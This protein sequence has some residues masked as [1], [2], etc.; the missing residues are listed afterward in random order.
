M[1]TLRLGDCLEVLKTLPDNSVDSVVTD[2]PYGLA[3][4]GK[5][6]DYDV[7]GQDIW[8]EC[9]RVLKPGGHLLAFF[10]TRTYHRGAIKIEDAGFEIRD[11][12][13]WLYGSGFPKSTDVSK[14]IDKEAGVERE[15]VGTKNKS[16]SRG[17]TRGASNGGHQGGY[18]YS[19]TVP[20]TTPST[21]EAIQWQ[22]WGTAL[23]PANEPIVVA[24]KP[25]EK[26]LTVAQNVLK[27]GTGALNIDGSR[28]E[29]VKPQTVQGGRS[30]SGSQIGNNFEKEPRWVLSDN[31]QGRWPA[32]VLLDEEAAALLPMDDKGLP[33][34]RFFY[35]AK[36]SKAERNAGL[37]GM[38]EVNANVGDH[39]PSGNMSQRLHGKENRPDIPRQNFHP[40]VKPIKLM[41]YLIKLV[42][43]PG[44]VVCDPFGGSGT[45]A[46]AA[47]EEGFDII[48]IEREPEYFAIKE[49]R[50]KAAI[51]R[52]K[53][54]EPVEP[55]PQ[56]EFPA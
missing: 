16:A 36:A 53:N 27:W 35:Q 10:G 30:I 11:Q 14:R 3:F 32:N 50:A 51:D 38:P 17:V 42:T 39:R 31:S 4:M 37:D 40:T 2:P 52:V 25:L 45:T 49:A 48:S 54:P 21:P 22:G 12:I 47:I 9:L 1:T 8:A 20:L 43:P 23:K 33:V 46:V 19:D 7:P 28:I 34:A 29:G 26:G 44:G 41:K 56:L 24:R 6:W 5:S 13:Q 15:V 18:N 55:D